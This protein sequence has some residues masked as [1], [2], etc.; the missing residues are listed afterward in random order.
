M[1]YFIFLKYLRSLEEF[2]KNPH[3][4]IPPKSPCANFQTL[5]IFKNQILF[6]KQISSLSA[7]PAHLDFRPRHGPLLL[8]FPTGRSPP[9]TGPRPLGRPS[10]P[11][12]QWRPTRLPPSSRGS[13]SSRAAFTPL[14]T[15]LTG[16][17]HPSS[18]TSGFARVRP[19]RHRLSPLRQHRPASH[20]GM[21]HEPLPPHHHSPL[22]LPPLNLAPAFNG[23]RAIKAAVIPATPPRRSP[24]PLPS[25]LAP[26]TSHPSPSSP[27]LLSRVGAPPHRA[28]RPP[29][30]SLDARLPHCR[31]RLG[32]PPTELPAFHS[33]SPAPWPAPLDTGTAGGQSSDE[34]GA[35]VHGRSTVD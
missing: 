21:P 29:P 12:R 6:G 16:W 9:P 18:L 25:T 22:I 3:V 19:R 33:S 24:Q 8:S 14:R 17:P 30:R 23:V 20:L 34:L 5:G 28:P 31:P 26:I 1:A 11:A 35:A 27:L 4:K 7:Q 2:R 13:A 15:R 10:W 32:E